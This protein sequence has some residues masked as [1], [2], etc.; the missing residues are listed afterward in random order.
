MQKI[1]PEIIVDFS[2]DKNCGTCII[3][4][5]LKN[6]IQNYKKTFICKKTNLVGEMS[7]LV[8]I[9]IGV[10][11]YLGGFTSGFGC[12]VAFLKWQNRRGMFVNIVKIIVLKKIFFSN[13]R[14]KRVSAPGWRSSGFA[15]WQRRKWARNLWSGGNW[16]SNCKVWRRPRY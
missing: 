15:Y 13:N 5:S 16:S 8:I 12:L 2:T 7:L 10:G 4:F 11:I 3:P 14:P 9:L 1:Q 6:I